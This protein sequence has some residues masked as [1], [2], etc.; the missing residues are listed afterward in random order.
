MGLTISTK[1]T[2]TMAV[3]PPE[4]T[5]EEQSPKPESITLHHNSD[6]INQGI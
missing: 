1:K 6:P 4:D 5:E 2:K 3:L